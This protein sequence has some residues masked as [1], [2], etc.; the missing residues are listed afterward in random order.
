[1][2]VRIDWNLEV[3]VDDALRG[4]GAVAEIVRQRSPKIVSTTERALT[5]A[6][7][8][9]RPVVIYKELEISGWHHESLHL[10]DGN[11]M[12]GDL[13]AAH[14]RAAQRVTLVVCTVSE[15]ISLLASK[16]MAENTLYGLA[17][18]GIG[19][20]AVEVLA[21]DVCAWLETRAAT[22]GWKSSIPLSPGVEG[23]HLVEGQMQIFK[24]LA[25]ESD[26]VHLRESFLMDPVKS[27]SFVVGMGRDVQ[28]HGT[29][30]DH[31]GLQNTCQYKKHNVP[32]T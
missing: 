5:S 28:A 16:E 18:D 6:F 24:S 9:L 30:C 26:V 19:S 21:N 27:L 17:L 7:H 23:W 31:C 2:P 15:A 32:N 20:A 4:Q 25:D 14:L 10:S 29:T 22:L 13:I 12:S 8:L 3:T 11:E 1:M